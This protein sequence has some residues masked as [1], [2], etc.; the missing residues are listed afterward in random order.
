MYLFPQ[1]RLPAKAIAEA[2][3]QGKIPD[4]FYCLQ[5][6]DATGVCVVPGSGFGQKEGTW[7][8]RSTFLPPEHLFDSFC[9]KLTK[10]HS[11]FMNQY[12]D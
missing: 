2:E 10:F 1:I 9:E 12:R 4:N 6:L 5:M 3:S 8:F 11:D 7:H